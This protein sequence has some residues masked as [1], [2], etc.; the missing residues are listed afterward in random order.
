MINSLLSESGQIFTE[1]D[2][3]ST[4]S[5]HI[6]VSLDEFNTLSVNQHNIVCFLYQ[7]WYFIV[8]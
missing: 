7:Y 2:S 1:S 8:L 6:C 4:F 5:G 3:E